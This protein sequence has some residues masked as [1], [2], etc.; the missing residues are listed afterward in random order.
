MAPTR[1]I[2]AFTCFIATAML[3]HSLRAENEPPK[4]APP[5]S[6]DK[7]P[8]GSA[9][10]LP[11]P[12][13]TGEDEVGEDDVADG[14]GDEV[15][16]GADEGKAAPDQHEDDS[17]DRGDL[18]DE[19]L[20]EG[21]DPAR[22]PPKGKGAVW[23]VVTEDEFKETLV[24]ATVQVLGNKTTTYTDV[25][26]RFRL[27]LPPGTYSLRVSYELHKS[28]RIDGVTIVPGKVIRLDTELVHDQGAVNVFE[29]AEEADKS[30]LEGLI[31][32]RQKAT[33]VG[34][35]V[36]RSDISKTPDRNAAQAA[37]RVVGATIVGGRFVYVR[38]LGDRYTDALLNGVPLPSPEPD[39]TAVPLDLFPTSVLNSITIAKTFTPD[40]PADFA[41]G[42]IRIE[43]REIPR[44]PL[45]ELSLRGGY[46]TNTTFRE[47][48]TYRGGGLDWLGIDDGTR[49]LPD[50]FPKDFVGPSYP[51]DQRTAA[52]RSINTYMSTTK[53]GTPPDHSLS[54]VA[55]NSWD[56]GNDRKL[57]AL[58]TV[59]WGRSY[60]VRRGEIVRIFT[61][62]TPSDTTEYHLA[63]DYKASSGNVRVNWGGFGSVT[64]GFSAQHRFSLTGIHTTTTDDRAQILTGFHNVRNAYVY[65]SR[66]AFVSRNLNVGILRGEHRFPSLNHAELDWNLVLSSATRNEPNRRDTVWSDAADTAQRT[67]VYVDAAESGRHFH[68]DQTEI[69]RGGGV[70]WSQPIGRA[71]SKL[72]LGGLV[73]LRDRD[74]NSR[75]LSLRHRPG[76]SP[77]NNPVLACRTG[78][79]NACNDTLFVNNDI[80]ST[81]AE[82]LQ[83]V[84]ARNDGDRYDASLDVHAGYVMADLELGKAFRVL[85]GERIEHTRQVIE[86]YNASG[87]KDPTLRA[88]INQSDLLPAASGS[89]S[90]SAKSKLRLAVAR[91]LARPQ[92]REL[93]PFTFQDYFGGRVEGGN[94]DLKLTNITNL[95]ARFEHFPTLREVLACS[96]FFKDFRNPI[97][98][99][100]KAGGDEGSVTYQNAEGA[101]LFGIELEARKGLGFLH[102]A[103]SNF[104]ASTNLT[105]ARSKIALRPQES[106]ALANLSR[107]MVNQAPWVLNLSLNYLGE[108]TRTSATLLFN[109]AGPRIATV[110]PV[111][112]DDVYEHARSMLDASVQ[113]GIVDHLDV[114]LE[115]RNL[116]N[117]AVL[118]T[119]GCGNDGLFQ[120]TWH[121]SCSKGKGE[122][123]SYYTEGATFDVTAS[124]GF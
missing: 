73:S 50:G 85:V 21:E 67:Y 29:V 84:E 17:S 81:S 38:G 116:L 107:A 98:Q 68:A 80:G 122:A 2:A 28:T 13:A 1:S 12:G 46:N 16:V 40:Y 95:D 64:Y 62:K 52:G 32:A 19:A 53:S 74:F 15:T 110:G 124:Y 121:F 97:E 18:D 102:E 7:A 99:I 9:P 61:P 120:N 59:N 103:L 65:S 87:V 39:R 51:A 75:V 8:S 6:S 117:S 112:L 113:Q 101:T 111:G 34:D 123:V 115:A 104:S 77:L 69:Q 24:E 4:G 23:G 89:W 42:S 55:G 44:E 35:S 43:T 70:D 118:L 94:P 119:Q 63:R 88:D 90:V 109:V 10:A 57:G 71:E 96:I 11:E 45:F 108:K 3:S 66:L 78:N 37:Q 30:T 41:G 54:V 106:I 20:L 26:G 79:V 47:R 5:A 36:G 58:G 105:F 22:P 76:A 93:A 83:L 56:F 33:I 25:D 27:E 92:L 48:L 60:T 114:K 82:A 14:E 72:K 31:L 100:I 49:A 91:T 86:P